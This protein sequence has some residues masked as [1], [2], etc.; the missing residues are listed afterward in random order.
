MDKVF[1]RRRRKGQKRQTTQ[2]QPADP[3]ARQGMICL[4]ISLDEF[5]KQNFS[6]MSMKS[7]R[8]GGPVARWVLILRLN[9]IAHG[10]RSIRLSMVFSF[11]FC[12][13]EVL[14]SNL[15]GI[16]APDRRLY[17][18]SLTLLA[19]LRATKSPYTRLSTCVGYI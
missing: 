19:R 14:E 12:V 10:P 8:R 13:K 2:R 9:Y 4:S 15:E 17:G 1:G 6:S 7:S 16:L 5:S 11:F 3:P 18:R